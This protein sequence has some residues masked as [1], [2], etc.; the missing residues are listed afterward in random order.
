MGWFRDRIRNWLGVQDMSNSKKPYDNRLWFINDDDEIRRQKLQEYL[1]WFSGDSDELLN[2]YTRGNFRE[3]ATEPIFNRN[4]K[5]FFWAISSTEARIK[6]THSGVPRA[7]IET[8]VNAIGTPKMVSNDIVLQKRIDDIVKDNDLLQIINQEQM[9]LTLVTGSGAFKINI[10]TN[11]SKKPIITFY[12]ARNVKFEI[13]SRRIFGIKFVDYYTGKDRK[14]YALIDHRYIDEGNSYVEYKLYR[15]KPGQ[16]EGEFEKEADE[17]PLDTIPETEGMQDMVFKGLNSILG[18]PSVFFKD[19]IYENYGRSIFNGKVDLFDDLDQAISQS[20]NT[21]RKSTPV[22][23]Y[24]VDLLERTP[25]GEPKLPVRYDRTYVATPAGRNGDGERT[26]K[27]ETTQPALNFTQ[28]NIEA[29]NI[30][31]FILTGVLSPATMGIDVAKRDNADAQREKEK[32]TL[33]TRNNII[34]R[35]VDIL[36]NV[37]LLALKL[38]DYIINPTLENF[39]DYEV[40]VEFEE[41]AN[42]SFENQIVILANALQSGALSVERYVELLWAD[43]LDEDAKQKEVEYIQMFMGQGA[44]ANPMDALFGSPNFQ[45]G[46]VPPNYVAPEEE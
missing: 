44:M 39:T 7:I 6:R 27:I 37:V 38:E 41:F 17:V 42:P 20:A 14:A 45:S 11:I 36:E 30:L 40:G 4:K 43:T 29:Q 22:E 46:Q 31:S 12:D 35:Q 21:V 32:I 25:T 24:P 26:G 13:V 33:M 16:K 2:F 8:L 10:D 1:I 28:Y 18:V 9:P 5:D 3:F 19:T 23:Y 34:M 15:L